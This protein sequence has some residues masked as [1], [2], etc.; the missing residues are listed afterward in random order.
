MNGEVFITC[1]CKLLSGLLVLSW[2]LVGVEVT[3]LLEFCVSM[4]IVWSNQF[5]EIIQEQY[6]MLQ[7]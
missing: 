1:N 7:F 5:R 6:K 4:H 3:V 2:T